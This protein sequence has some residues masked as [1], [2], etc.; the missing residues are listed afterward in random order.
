MHTFFTYLTPGIH[1]FWIQDAR[2]PMQKS[3][4]EFL[5]YFEQFG[6]KISLVLNK[7]DKIK[8]Q[9][10]KNEF[11]TALTTVGHKKKNH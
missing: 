1:P 8:S 9:K 4:L 6:R 10:E 7:V 3:D 2:H 5:Q 11:K